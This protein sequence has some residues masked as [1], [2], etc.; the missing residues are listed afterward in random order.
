MEWVEIGVGFLFVV[1]GGFT[2]I[3][4]EASL[5]IQQ[6]IAAQVLRIDFQPTARTRAG[7]RIVG[8][9]LVILGFSL[10]V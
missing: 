2:A 5:A 8:V 6:R 9:L 1:L 7:A 10:M 4:T 3:S